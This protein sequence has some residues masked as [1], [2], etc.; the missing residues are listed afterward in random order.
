MAAEMLWLGLTASVISFAPPQPKGNA[1][2]GGE[3]AAPHC[4]LD[5]AGEMAFVTGESGCVEALEVESGKCKWRTDSRAVPLAAFDGKVAILARIK[6]ESGLRAQI[7]DARTGKRLREAKVEAPDWVYFYFVN[8]R[9]ALEIE[10][11]GSSKGLLIKWTARDVETET[12]NSGTAPPPGASIGPEA[13]SG[14]IRIDLD[15]G[16]VSV[17]TADK[18]QT[19]DAVERPKLPEGVRAAPY[20]R[21]QPE[22][23]FWSGEASPLV[24]GETLV[25]FEAET[26]G[27]DEV[28]YLHIWDWKTGKSKDRVKLFQ[29]ERARPTVYPET[30]RFALG[31]GKE[32]AYFSL[33]TGNREPN[34][35]DANRNTTLSLVEPPWV[36]KGGEYRTSRTL[37][38]VETKTVKVLWEREVEA[39]R[40]VPLPQ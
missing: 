37:R 7:L 20:N 33:E 26:D 13:A 23:T 6:G 24:V 29:G 17:Q 11:R 18:F 25:A 10:R 39:R 30:G 15:R 4:V 8:T 16:D 19:D 3:M 34:V 31:T 22:R 27:K 35:A 40:W 28:L 32:V 12:R 9:A 38:A 1:F 5:F 14:V 2:P 36:E 21:V